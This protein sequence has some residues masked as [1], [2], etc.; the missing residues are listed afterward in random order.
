MNAKGPAQGRTPGSPIRLRQGSGGPQKP[1][2]AEAGHYVRMA[3]VAGLVIVA[4]VAAPSVSGQSGRSN[5]F[6]RGELQVIGGGSRI[7][8][9]VRDLQ[10]SE[11]K[12][13]N[14]V[15]VESVQPDGPAARAG[16]QRGDV[17]TRFDGETVRSV[18]QFRRLVQETPPWRAV[19]ATVRRE[20]RSTDLSLTPEEG[21]TSGI[22]GLDGKRLEEQMAQLEE[23]MKRIPLDIDID[24]D[25]QGLRGRS[26]LGVTVEELTPQLAAYFG[27]KDGVLVTAVTEDSSAS[28]AGLKA[29]DVIVSLNGQNVTSSGDLLRALR[30]AG[31][32][33]DVTVG[34]VRDKKE[35]S[36]KA[37]LDDVGVRR[38]VRRI[39][40]VRATPA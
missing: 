37:R 34:I 35:T 21:S 32:D 26:R 20:G 18:R 11:I 23:R 3:V 4:I 6:R 8:A 30:G 15:F 10:D 12:A 24:I 39:R 14:G 33:A 31:T 19:Q 36:L 22:F 1:A 16:L 28:R 27:A 40:P 7:G 17:V 9:S 25:F 38:P 13:G 5:V 2:E 29:G